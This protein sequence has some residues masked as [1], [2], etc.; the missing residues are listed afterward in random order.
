MIDAQHPGREF[1]V[2][3]LFIR[4][5][6]FI[7]RK[8][9]LIFIDASGHS[10][11]FG[12]GTGIPVVIRTKSKSTYAKLAIDPEKHLGEFYMNGLLTVERGTIYDFL[13]LMLS[14]LEQREYPG[15]LAA[16]NRLRTALRPYH[17]YNPI[18][19]A[20][21]NVAHH[22]DLDSGLY[23]LF[24]DRDH[25]YS[26]AYFEFPS[27]GL[28][29]AQLAKK[30][31][32]AA[33]L[34]LKPG[35]KVLD[36]GSGWGGLGLYLAEMAD[37]DVTGVTLSEEQFRISNDRAKTRGLSDKARFLLKDYREL[38]T[39]FDRIVSVGM[40]EHVGA[41]HYPEYFRTIRELLSEDGVAIVHSIN[42]STG[43]S[44]TNPWIEKYIF[45]GGAIPALS[46]VVP[47]IEQ[48][49]LYITDVEI[50]RL[51][52]AETLKAWRERFVDHWDRVKAIYDERFCRMWEFYLASSET[53]F[54]YQ[55]LNNFQ[56]QLTRSQHSLP[57]TRTYIEQEE[58]RLRKLE[59][60][61]CHLIS[62]PA[63]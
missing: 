2:L 33:K 44:A 31:H 48:S 54:R 53:A 15:W 8:G 16:W 12:D 51:H 21:R 11:Q 42:R 61:G 4:V 29:A 23:D 59:Q 34:N 40:F 22:Y 60:D 36:I 20:K 56:V 37:V 26:C 30:R 6:A 58:E 43:P 7:V 27:T 52:Y 24:L 32:L 9:T 47:V 25:Q 10:H 49:G 14:N 57:I 39:K 35:M 63:E 38:D 19:R 13:A 62:I 55:G 18:G 46:E 17:Q 45:P 50:L 41:R 5:L 28:E 3:S 1:Q